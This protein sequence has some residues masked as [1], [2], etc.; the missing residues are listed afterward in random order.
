[1]MQHYLRAFLGLSA[2]AIPWVSV[3]TAPSLAQRQG[4]ATQFPLMS[5]ADCSAV[6][7]TSGVTFM[8]AEEN[9]QVPIGLQLYDYF[10]WM[11]APG[12]TA[13]ALVCNIDP[14]RFD[15][16]TLQMGVSDNRRQ[17]EE[18]MT[19]NIYQSGTVISTYNLVGPGDLVEA[20]IDLTNA[21]SSRPGSIAIE[22]FC[23]SVIR[24]GRGC[25]FHL[26]EGALAA[27]DNFF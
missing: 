10:Y 24:D 19:V 17:Y 4:A 11:R 22:I 6:V 14:N 16:L 7:P 8:Y 9:G 13:A 5:N 18:S 25:Y 23:D 1:M 26:L 20:T 3:S 15:T 2:L 27:S 12:G 21:D